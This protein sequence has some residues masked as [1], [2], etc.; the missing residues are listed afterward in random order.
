MEFPEAFY[1]RVLDNINDG[2]YFVDASRKITLWNRAAERITGY[3]AEEVIGSSCADDI[4]VHV[5]ALGNS[6][7]TGTC[8]LAKTLRDGCGN[9]GEV[10]LHHKDGHR[11]PVTVSIS[12]LRDADGN[13]VG[14]VE[15]FRDNSARIMEKEL[16]DSFRKAASIDA[17]T[18]LPNRRY[19]DMRLHTCLE[20]LRR[21]NIPFGIIFADIDRFK[22]VNDN[23][24]HGIGDD[25]LRMVAQTL[26]S[27]VRGHDVA[28]RWGGE[29]FLIIVS[30]IS[31]Q[32]IPK[33]ANKLRIL[34]NNS[35]FKIG[36]RRI[37]VTMTMGAVSAGKDD[38]EESLI[39][40]ADRLLYEGKNAGRNCVKSDILC[41]VNPEQ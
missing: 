16:L 39:A 22:D 30:H 27:N 40:K 34:V 28:G 24:G 15:T 23:F 2:V 8:P 9:H 14:A 12:A 1:K 35:F 3:T 25:V 10:F 13:I 38:S 17:L 26:A 11:L 18:E 29:E 19:L 5:D 41:V 36:E 6:L 4:L 7:C 33:L 21:H 31:E 37:Q 32:N 20:E